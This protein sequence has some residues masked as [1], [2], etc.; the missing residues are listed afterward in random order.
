MSKKICIVTTISLPIDQF[1]RFSFEEYYMHGFDVSV[2]CDMDED[3]IKTL[4]PYVH[5]IP[6]SMKRGISFAGIKSAFK[7]YK[8]FKKEK[9]D[10]V[11]YSTPNA[12]LYASLASFFARVPKR[13]YCQWG[14]IF[15]SFGGVKRFIFKTIEKLVCKLST[16]IQ[17]DSFGNL[18][19]CRDLGF[20]DDK[21]SRVV[22]NGSAN[23]V[24]LH[25]FDISKKQEYRLNIRS[26]YGFS[27]NDIVIGF[28]GRLMKDKGCDELI[29]AF[30]ILESRNSNVKMLFVGPTEKTGNENKELLDYFYSNDNIVKIGNVS[31]AERY[32]AAMDI[33]LFPSYREGFGSVVIEAE[34]MGLP[35]VVSDI[36][37]PTDGVIRDKTGFVVP[38][39]DEV[40]LADKAQVLIDSK[41]LRESMGKSG[42]QLVE[43]KFDSDILKTEIVKNREWILSR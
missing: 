28:L 13:L 19:F 34:A 30:K 42:R 2:M 20:Y 38:V 41:E 39:K 5:A 40:S 6:V 9:F 7:M 33:F 18:N 35:V 36:P 15:V 27:D 10:L 16:D 11:Q 37:G 17:P 24:N 43:D 23:G 32:L 22:Y 1:I 25:K 26:K 4:P 31:D 14:M 3:F 8:V 29:G 12:S 21:K